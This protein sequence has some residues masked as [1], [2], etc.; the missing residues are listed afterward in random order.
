MRHRT[1]R[2][3]T[4][5]LLVAGMTI[6]SM[7]T[8]LARIIE[9]DRWSFSDSYSD[10]VCGIDVEID[11]TASGLFMIRAG[12][13]GSPAFFVSNVYEFREVVT[14]PETGASMV[15]R[16][17]G[18]FREV[19]ATQ[20]DGDI[21]RFRAQEAGQLFVIEDSAGRVVYRDRGLLVFESLFDTFGDDVPGGE[22]LS[23]E[24]VEMRGFPGY[25]DDV[26]G[27]VEDLIG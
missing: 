19:T 18:N 13:P 21:Y 4:V 8:A 27:I 23:F 15:V 7:S 5:A 16:G 1:T 24:V 10:E 11:V 14:N 6:A 22:E 2:M 12:R 26:C 9:Q 25:L 20:V 17:K 3:L